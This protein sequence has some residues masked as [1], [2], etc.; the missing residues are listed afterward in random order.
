[1]GAIGFKHSGNFDNLERFLKG[2]DRQQLISILNAMGQEGV[3]ALS[4]ATPIDS[5]N[6][7]GSWGYEVKANKGSYSLTWTNSNVNKGVPIA[8]LIQYGHATGTGGYVE[9]Y[10]YINPAIRPVFD[11]ISQTLWEE[12]TKL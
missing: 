10:D 2:H 3:D 9:G 6:T 7:A 1:M 4:S 11:R 5:G 12:M 8:I